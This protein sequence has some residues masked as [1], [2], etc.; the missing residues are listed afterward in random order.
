MAF[1]SSIY[2]KN[3][4]IDKSATPLNADEIV[5]VFYNII[6]KVNTFSVNS[7][8]FAKE[9]MNMP[10]MARDTNIT[11]QNIT[12]LV[13]LQGGSPTK[14]ADSFFEKAG[15]REKLYKSNFSK[16][17]SALKSKPIAPTGVS[18]FGQKALNF[19]AMSLGL[20]GFF[21]AL[22][23]A[24]NLISKMPG[25][26]EGLK[27]MFVA[28]GEGLSALSVESLLKFGA[29]LGAGALFGQ[30]SLKFQGKAVIGMGA[31]GLGIGAFFTGLA[32]GGL[33]GTFI[34]NSSGIRD[35]MVN[36]A[37]GLG[38][39]NTQTLVGFG[40]LLVAGGLFGQTS[41]A[42]QGKAVLGM[43]AIGLGIGAFFSGL[44]LG[45]KGL[46][47]IGGD[48]TKLKDLL[49][50]LAEGLNAISELNG[51]KLLGLTVT[52]PAFGVALIGFLVTEGIAG[53]AEKL[54]KGLDKAIN[55]LL[56]GGEY[57]SPIQKIAE[58]MTKISEISDLTKA[59]DGVKNLTE[60]LKIISNLSG[61]TIQNALNKTAL[62]LAVLERLN[63]G[64]L[65]SNLQRTT[66]QAPSPAGATPR[67]VERS[68]A[69]QR[70]LD[71]VSETLVNYIKSVEGFTP[72]ATWDYQ[73]YTNGYG[74]EAKGPD[75]VITEQEADRR[76]REKL[77]KTQDFVSS[78][79][80]KNG[81][82]FNR[83]QLD[84]LTSFTY[85][86]GPGGL[87]QLTDN[88][89][90]SFEEI[91]EKMVLYNMAG[92][93]VLTGLQRRRNQ[94]LQMFTGDTSAPMA[95]QPQNQTA[96]VTPTPAPSTPSVGASIA[97]SS[98]AINQVRASMNAT[99]PTVVVNNSGAS[100]D[101]NKPVDS[102]I[103]STIDFDFTDSMFGAPQYA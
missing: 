19:G 62:I 5:Q 70:R 98:S 86:L 8:I 46:D 38:A 27:N 50:N 77:Q 76:L 99:P 36:L 33:I 4:T 42:T 15:E 75:E 51:M 55:F 88:G 87:K 57:K 41:F 28:L 14:K 54:T 10:M 43:G 101:K 11:R 23:L 26:Y 80:T 82:E 20:V 95:T 91:K 1:L 9:S 12:K 22:T 84:A 60:T 29:L 79:L 30:T 35:M 44:S 78:Y 17:S 3:K 7:R 94:E 47:F 83:G 65:P 64:K 32:A 68:V 85:N 89:K 93:K 53:I 96:G 13:K 40:A 90:R 69:D 21:G 67:P 71:V 25:A 56:G 72:K 45:A 100:K 16:E 31:V 92:G 73:Q 24:G 18:G 2:K 49:V 81:Y 34:D 59:N 74:T 6:P 58:D 102:K 52:L 66:P 97:S 39:F 37:E 48:P 63:S 61:D 103:A